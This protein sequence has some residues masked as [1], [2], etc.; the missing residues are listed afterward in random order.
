MIQPKSGGLS[1]ATKY[2][3]KNLLVYTSAKEPHLRK[4]E[5]SQPY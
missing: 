2:K 5:E 3:Q 4:P 1:Q